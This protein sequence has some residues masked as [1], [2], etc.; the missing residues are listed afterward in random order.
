MAFVNESGIEAGADG[1]DGTTGE[2]LDTVVVLVE[3]VA[4]FLGSDLI[5]VE[6]RGFLDES[7]FTGIDL[8]AEAADV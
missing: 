4:D 7:L 5:N 6:Q 2:A 3:A 1:L 8:T